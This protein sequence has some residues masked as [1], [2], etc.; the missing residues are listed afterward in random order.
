M[1]TKLILACLL[2]ALLNLDAVS[3]GQFQLSRPVVMGGVVGYLLG[4]YLHGL[5][6]GALLELI[7]VGYLPVGVHIPPDVSLMGSLGPIWLIMA[8][9]MMG[10][11]SQGLIGLMTILVIPIGY[12]GCLS[13]AALRHHFD[14]YIAKAAA[15]IETGEYELIYRLKWWGLFLN[16]C[17]FLGLLLLFVLPIYLILYLGGDPLSVR[18]GSFF[19]FRLQHSLASFSYLLPAVGL[20]ALISLFYIKELALYLWGGF[21]W[22]LV[23]I[24]I[25]QMDILW[26]TVYTLGLMLTLIPMLYLL[27]LKKGIEWW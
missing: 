2:S 15:Y 6:F 18:G 14:G 16:Y 11:Q 3:F 27:V 5:V 10:W 20:A 24:S 26:Y 1:L 7:W 22:G 19:N 25:V 4:D 12:A 17:R 21:I 13:E 23:L 8:R 9:Q